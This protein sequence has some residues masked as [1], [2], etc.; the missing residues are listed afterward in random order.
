MKRNSVFAIGLLTLALCFGGQCDTE[1]IQEGENLLVPRSWQ[2]LQGDEQGS[3]FNAVHT[4]VAV[5]S[6]RKWTREVGEMAF[7]SPVISL[8]GTIWVGTA[9]GELIGLDPASGQI[10]HRRDA[11]GGSIVSTPAVDDSARVFF[12]SQHV[13]SGNTTT[14]LLQVFDPALNT[15]QAISNQPAFSSFASP[16]IW[17]DYV[18]VTA[19]EK[20]FAF[21]R[22]NL[23]L[24]A[25]RFCCGSLV[26]GGDGGLLGSLL[27][28][29]G[30]IATVG[31]TD[32]IGL[33]D[34]CPDYNPTR[35]E[36]TPQTSV[37][38][39]DNPS[40][41]EDPNRPI[42]IMA[43]G[44]QVIAFDFDPF[45]QNDF[46]RLKIRWQRELVPVECGQA[47]L[48]VTTPAVLNT[49]QVVVGDNTGRLRS[50]NVRDGSDFWSFNAGKKIMCPP[51]AS[52]RQIY[53]VTTDS[54]IILD[55][56]GQEVTSRA[57]QGIG[58]GAA[59]SLDFVHVM[60]SDGI[61]SF[62][63]N[64]NSDFEIF[65]DVI[66]DESHIG[67]TTPALDRDGTVYL[68]TPNG[69]VVAYGPVQSAIQIFQ[70]QIDWLSP[71]EGQ[72]IPTS[73]G[74]TLR[75]SLPNAF[76]GNI[77]INSSIDGQL[78]KFEVN[79]L[80]EASCVT[81]KKLTA[82]QHVLTA[83]ATTSDGG[84]K[85]AQITIQAAESTPT[86][87][88]TSPLHDS[89]F[90]DVA[91]ITFT[92]TVA[93]LD[94][95]NFPGDRVQWKSSLDG[96]LGSGLS[97]VRRLTALG[98]HTITATATDADGNMGEASIIVHIFHD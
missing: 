45:A 55:S 85:S 20:I 80:S 56:N 19:G 61:H 1:P 64:P 63:I 24:V 16:K 62:D 13:V 26:C 72:Q 79:N 14:T 52:I 69:L 31:I 42:V 9:A 84:T 88:I 44:K 18:F 89:A 71:S 47:N 36:A 92:A 83:F 2:Q 30:C 34:F 17:R 78:C 22:F 59:L 58:G 40:I 8:Q 5:Q 90:A 50:F 27:G 68:S 67:F 75:V 25:E 73:A 48:Q 77:S 4:D 81:S 23:N 51:V 54:L 12:L 38:I 98:D 97:F 35:A 21:H 41:V 57:L 10:I 93:D 95:P 39:V 86:V 46:Q 6:S 65:D 33:T 15:L 53:V 76:T 94:E 66:L 37:A 91:P 28:F 7:S 74:Q 43:S 70:P 82:G 11:A 29:Y 32:A 49:D 96:D 60:T 87:T 3:G